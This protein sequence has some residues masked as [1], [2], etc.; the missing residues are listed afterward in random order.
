MT[1]PV[2]SKMPHKEDDV[3]FLA[4]EFDM[5][6]RAAAELVSDNPESAEQLA[7]AEMRRQRSENRL[8]DVPVPKQ[9]KADVYPV[10]AFESTKPLPVDN[11][12]L[13]AG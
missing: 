9:D 8:A 2:Q 5:S 1:N 12:R 11:E 4:E 3:A 7:E 6:P 10:P 13:G